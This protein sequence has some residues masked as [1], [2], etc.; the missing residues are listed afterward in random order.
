MKKIHLIRHAKSSWENE[1]L[2]DV[3]RPLNQRGIKN[4][5]LMA[6][7][8]VDA[9]CGFE[10]VFSSPAHRAQSTIKLLSNSIP[11]IPL[12]WQTDERLYCFDSN[13]LHHWFTELDESIT[14]VVIIGHNPALTDFCN[15]LSN[16]DIKNIP[17]CAY[18]QLTANTELQWPQVSDVSFE[19][20]RFITPK[21]LTVPRP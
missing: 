18:V 20:T 11:E 6:S 14:E 8:I 21:E 16:S 19:L 9:G 12:K 15:E 1:R 10:N 5:Q 7:H 13:S 3:N 2:A 4:A 17:T